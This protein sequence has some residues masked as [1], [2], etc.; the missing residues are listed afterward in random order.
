[1]YRCFSQI[2]LPEIFQTLIDLGCLHRKQIHYTDD[3][4]FVLDRSI[5]S[6]LIDKE[7]PT[8]PGQDG[9]ALFC[10]NF[11]DDW[12]LYAISNGSSHTYSLLKLREQEDDAQGILPADGDTPG[13]T[14]S[15]IDFQPALLLTCLQEPSLRNRKGLS[16]EL[17]RVVAAPRQ[18]H[19]PVLRSYFR[20]PAAKASYLVAELYVSHVASFADK[21]FMPVSKHYSTL[22]QRASAPRAT[23]RDRRLSAFIEQ[24]NMASGR[25]ICDHRYIYVHDPQ[26]LT[27]HEK[28]AILATHTGNVSFHSFA[29]EVR[30]HACFLFSL[31]KLPLPFFGH[32]VYASAVRADMSIDDNELQGITPYYNPKSRWLRQQKAQHP[33]Y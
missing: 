13:V 31:A 16:A 2:P 11:Y 14:I 20:S 30:F 23:K 10:E 12:Y 6:I 5:A 26:H 27:L 18:N 8:L 17:N 3:G 28:L 4:F 24:N 21:S 29:A 1:M 9:R 22:F 25:T 7:I 15:F 32:S 33:H 19:H